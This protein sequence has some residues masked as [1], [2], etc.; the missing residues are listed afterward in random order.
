MRKPKEEDIIS[1]GEWNLPTSWE[2]VTLGQICDIR[3]LGDDAVSSEIIAI[4]SSRT[5][6]EVDA[7]PIDFYEKICSVLGFMETEIPATPTDTVEYLGETYRV[8]TKDTLKVG[9]FTAFMNI[10]AQDSGNIPAMLAVV[11]RREGEQFDDRYENE[12]FQ[13]RKEMF[14]NMPVTKAMPVIAFF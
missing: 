14:S 1:Y 3:K 5:K 13:E 12:V 8:N 6:E 11:C 9:E 2:E 7:L 4:L 10:S